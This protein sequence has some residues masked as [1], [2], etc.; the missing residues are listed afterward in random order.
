MSLLESSNPVLA[1]GRLQ[2]ALRESAAAEGVA[3]VSGVINKTTLCLA[4]AVGFG[5]IGHSVVKANPGMLGM[6][7]LVAFVASLGVGF[8][9]YGRPA[10]AAI[11]TPIY[12]AA[13]GFLLGAVALVLDGILARNGIRVAGGVALQ[14]FLVTAGVGVACLML[15]RSGAVRFSERGAFIL[16][17]AV[18]GIAI[19]YLLTFVLG[20][21]GVSVPFMGI[22]TQ[23]GASNA[24]Y[25]GLAINGVI[26]VVA[27]LTL[28]ADFQQVD[29]AVRGGAPASAEWY[30]AYGLVVSLVWIYMESLKIVFRLA[31]IFGGKRD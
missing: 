14:A 1:D 19:T 24:A 6:V 23:A 8:A 20:L 16:W 27:A 3:T 28:V 31:M 12:A 2:P 25:I 26:L 7:N 10:W 15:Y 29:M 18:L 21:F 13:Q 5:A 30:L 22:P 9:L 11:L 4:V 17:C